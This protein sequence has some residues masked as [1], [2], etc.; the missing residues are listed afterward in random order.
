MKDKIFYTFL[1]DKF[2]DWMELQHKIQR[3]KS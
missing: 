3:A 1:I 2:D